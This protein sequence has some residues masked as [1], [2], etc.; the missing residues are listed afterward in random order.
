M[1]GIVVTRLRWSRIL[2]LLP[3]PG[4]FL[5]APPPPTDCLLAATVLLWCV[6]WWPCTPFPT[7]LV[8]FLLLFVQ[9]CKSSTSTT[10]WGTASRAS[11]TRQIC[12]SWQPPCSSASG[13]GWDACIF[14]RVFVCR[15]VQYAQTRRSYLSVSRLFFVFP[16]CCASGC[17]VVPSLGSLSRVCVCVCVCVCATQHR[18]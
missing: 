3:M 4:L 1:I 16:A 2:P 7:F 8:C 10:T 5:P 15:Y 11:S 9:S 12:S 18:R 14:A 17:L 6:S 13:T